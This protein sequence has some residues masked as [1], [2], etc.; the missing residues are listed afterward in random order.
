M[1]RDLLTISKIT[2]GAS[3]EYPVLS[4]QR[5]H[6]RTGPAD[7]ARVSYEEITWTLRCL[8]KATTPTTIGAFNAQMASTLATRGQTVVL[9]EM[10]QS[11]SLIAAGSLPGFP[12]TQWTGTPEV[13]YGG[14]QSFD[15]VVTDRR[16]VVD[17]DNIAEHTYTI[18][19]GTQP[20]GGTRTRRV[21]SVRTG[22][23]DNAAAW[24]AANIFAPAQSA[25][26]AGGLALTKRT[27]VN[28]DAA[29]CQ[30]EYEMAP[31]TGSGGIAGL[32]EAQS[33]DRTSI[34]TEGVTRRVV[35]GYAAGTGAAAWV[36]GRRLAQTAN[37]ALVREE[38]SPAAIPS[39]RLSFRFE[40]VSGAALAAFPGIFVLEISERV[41]GPMGG[42]LGIEAA[43]FLGQT[44]VLR[45]GTHRAYAYRQSSTIRFLGGTHADHGLTALF[46]PDN[47]SGEPM[48][49]YD[50][51]GR[52]RVVTID[53]AFVF[54]T[55]VDP[56]PVPRTLD[57]LAP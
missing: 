29:W 11:T 47:L 32:L 3:A 54:D 33:E 13:S 49:D 30:Y 52:V 34:D 21:G 39:E 6:T 2:I 50:S 57:N 53:R 46:N 18:E 1:A 22:N 27:T 55:P 10:G 38:T 19:T 20:K 56:L 8:A 5:S 44:P 15:L 45:R 48:V 51:Q 7:Q 37:L 24:V 31:L 14:W 26:N 42:G 28:A 16:P 36:A 23:G 41:S 12:Q 43:E 40:Y 4:V 35:S 9:T 25:A 17:E